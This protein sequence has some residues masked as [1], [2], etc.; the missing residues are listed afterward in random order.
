MQQNF[1]KSDD[2]CKTLSPSP[3]QMNFLLHTGKHTKKNKLPLLRSRKNCEWWRELSPTGGCSPCLPDKTQGKSSRYLMGIRS[4]MHVPSLRSSSKLTSL[5]QACLQQNC[6]KTQR[7]CTVKQKA[8]ELQA[9]P[10]PPEPP[11]STPPLPAKR[12]SGLSALRP[13]HPWCILGPREDLR[14]NP[15]PTQMR[16]PVQDTDMT[17]RAPYLKSLRQIEPCHVTDRA[18][19]RTSHIIFH[20]QYHCPTVSGTINP[21]LGLQNR[22]W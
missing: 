13:E 8:L 9:S 12:P 5:Q 1:R 4:S 22:H 3:G 19:S 20:R 15:Y 14:L 7:I 10:C 21:P 16:A 18:A 11:G 6:C 17:A 2:L